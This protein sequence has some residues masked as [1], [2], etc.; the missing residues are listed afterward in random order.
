LRSNATVVSTNWRTK[1]RS[2]R[3]F[4]EEEDNEKGYDDD[5][6]QSVP[7]RR[8]T[9]CFS[10]VVALLRRRRKEMQSLLSGR[11][12]GNTYDCYV[13]AKRRNTCI[14]IRIF[15]FGGIYRQVK[16]DSEF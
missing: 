12:C 8:T 16:F 11:I 5:D 10:T 13:L 4:W 14:D 3:S 6:A 15:V 1:E 2:L 7:R 9:R